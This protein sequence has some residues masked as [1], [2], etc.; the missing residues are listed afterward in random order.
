MPAELFRNA[1]ATPI[2]LTATYTAGG[3]TLTVSSAAQFDITT[4]IYRVAIGNAAK[5]VW[6]VDSVS[7][8]VLTGTAESNDGNA[9]IGDTVIIVNSRQVGERF[10]QSP[11]A[12]EMLA[13]SGVSGGDFYGLRRRGRPALAGGT[14][15]NQGGSTIVVANGVEIFKP[16][17]TGTRMLL[18]STPGTPFII[19]FEVFPG[20]VSG[21]SGTNI[22]VC[23]RES[24]T[25]KIIGLF[26][27][28]DA[29]VQVNSYSATSTFQANLFTSSAFAWRPRPLFFRLQN[30]AT[31]VIFEYSGDG[32]EW[33]VAVSQL[34]TAHFTTAPNQYGYFSDST[35]SGEQSVL[36][37][38][39][40]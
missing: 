34:L 11:A 4:G 2:T 10:I 21:G 36:S 26:W 40:S 6:R 5:T 35:A 16:A 32:A 12:G 22:G 1:L 8:S 15:E 3:S 38:L 37:I 39:L 25:G 24:A 7:G 14:W 30:D 18:V 20:L 33:V 13:P 23:F 9:A 27:R 29:I 17:V 31:N 28:G 19:E